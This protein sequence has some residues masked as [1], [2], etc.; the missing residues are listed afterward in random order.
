MNTLQAKFALFAKLMGKEMG[1]APGQWYLERVTCYGGYVIVEAGES[2][3]EHHP[4]LSR[5]LPK[6]QMELALDMAIAVKRS[7]R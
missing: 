2:G 5:R 6:A 1:S 3:S 4:L 7:E